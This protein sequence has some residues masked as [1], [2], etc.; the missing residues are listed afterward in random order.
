M[1]KEDLI[2][3]TFNCTPAPHDKLRRVL[4]SIRPWPCR[5][6]SWL[7][8]IIWPSPVLVPPSS[9]T[10]WLQENTRKCFTTRLTPRWLSEFL[11]LRLREKIIFPM[12]R[13]LLS[14]CFRNTIKAR[15]IKNKKYTEFSDNNFSVAENPVY[16]ILPSDTRSPP[17]R[18]SPAPSSSTPAHGCAPDNARRNR[19]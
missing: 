16:F 13:K 7:P 18:F 10:G 3:L 11:I 19:R 1:L 17:P 15:F 8:P 2:D 9:A 6:P 4:V 5:S 12:R 14:S